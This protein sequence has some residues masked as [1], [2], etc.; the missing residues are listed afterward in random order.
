MLLSE[1]YIVTRNIGKRAMKMG[2]WLQLKSIPIDFCY[3][4]EFNILFIEL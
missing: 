4:L 2:S 3:S 1:Q